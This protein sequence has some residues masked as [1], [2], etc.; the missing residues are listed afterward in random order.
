MSI[1]LV[2]LLLSDLSGKQ[3]FYLR[4]REIANSKQATESCASF[5]VVLFEHTSE[6]LPRETKSTF[7]SCTQFGQPASREWSVEATQ[8]VQ[9][10]SVRFGCALRMRKVKYK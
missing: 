5:T 4:E 2:S 10:G 8:V 6:H 9:L 3:N 7:F 1:Y